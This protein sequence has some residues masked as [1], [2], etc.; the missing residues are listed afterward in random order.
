MNAYPI[1]PTPISSPL[2]A[3]ARP[4]HVA[5]QILRPPRSERRPLGIWALGPMVTRFVPGRLPA[6]RAGR[7][8]A[9]RVR[10]AIEGLGDLIDG[11]EFHYPQELDRGE[12]R[13]DPRPLDEARL[14]C[15]AGGS[16]SRS[17]LRPRRPRLPR[18]PAVR[19][20]ALGFAARRGRIFGGE[21]GVTHDR[22]ARGSRATTTRSRRPTRRAGR[23]FIDAWA[24]SH[25][26]SGSAAPRSASSTR[27]PSR[28]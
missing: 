21:L 4:P 27:T 22:L 25:S 18:P 23:S 3:L 5:A 6:P 17:P 26:G 1:M 13:R 16:A 10:R 11:Y 9:D 8:T 15:L 2:P 24:Q 28:R 14:Y 12:P 19:A 20:E 7:A